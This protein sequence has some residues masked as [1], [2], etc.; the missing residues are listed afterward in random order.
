MKK[1]KVFVR[2]GS[3]SF[4]IFLVF[5]FFMVCAKKRGHRET[6]DEISFVTFPSHFD[7]YLMKLRGHNFDEIF[8]T[9]LI[10]SCLKFHQIV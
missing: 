7:H 1:Y 6:L 3:H 8:L 5:A 10:S 2:Q 9:K 4:A